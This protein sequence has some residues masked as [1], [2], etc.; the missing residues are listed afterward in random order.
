MAERFNAEKNWKSLMRGELRGLPKSYQEFETPRKTDF[1]S[2]VAAAIML[3]AVG[4]EGLVKN[5]T[6]IQ[7][8]KLLE[9]LEKT[10]K[11]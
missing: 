7:F 2:R 4:L 1:A 8:K 10:F 6:D 5:M 3:P 11:E 9:D